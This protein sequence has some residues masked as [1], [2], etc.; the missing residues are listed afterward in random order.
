MQFLLLI[1]GD[2]RA[3]AKMTPAETEKHF[4]AY[5]AYTNEL[6]KAGVMRGGEPLKPSGG[7]AKVTVR[8]GKTRV[9]D[10]PFTESK[11]VLGGFYMVECASRDEAIRWAAKC[12]GAS[13][14]T[15][16]VREVLPVPKR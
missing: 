10:G 5:M 9:V 1:H 12:P 16:E 7:G 2:E 13:E 15:M 6:V 14:G 8:D 4:A 11:E 3:Q